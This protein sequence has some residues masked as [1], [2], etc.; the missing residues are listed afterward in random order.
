VVASADPASRRQAD[1]R[2]AMSKFFAKQWEDEKE[3]VIQTE[4]LSIPTLPDER[5]ALATFIVKV[6]Y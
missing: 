1:I 2:E 4:E 5:R 6:G 3:E